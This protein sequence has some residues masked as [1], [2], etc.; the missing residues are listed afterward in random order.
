MMA[1]KL[2]PMSEG[3]T[4]VHKCEDTGRNSKSIAKV[5]SRMHRRHTDHCTITLI[6]GTA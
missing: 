3:T 2:V 1:K 4:M 6:Y 5:Q